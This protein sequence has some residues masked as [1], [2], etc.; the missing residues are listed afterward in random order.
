[1][2]NTNVSPHFLI[3]YGLVYSQTSRYY[4]EEPIQVAALEHHQKIRRD[5][6]ADTVNAMNNLAI[7]YHELGR[8]EE[9]EEL[10]IRVLDKWS[11]L[12][13]DLFVLEKHKKVTGVDHPF[14]LHVMSFLATTYSRLSRLKEAKE[15]YVVVLQKRRK[16]LGETHR[17]TL[18]VMYNLASTY[19]SLDQLKE[20]EELFV[21]L[22]AKQRV[23]WGD[24][25]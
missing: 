12:L 8:F 5:D 1:M 21:E 9:A 25:C 11:K 20:A 18:H 13:D 6:H 2:G 7:T 15:L 19:T 4:D 14:T 10:K 3:Q 22:L 17:H 16:I 23:V 24:D